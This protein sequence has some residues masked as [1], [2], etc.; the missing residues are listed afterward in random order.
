MKTELLTLAIE[1]YKKH[2]KE[3][4]SNADRIE[5]AEREN[6]YQ[7]FTA[8]K[9]KEM[10]KSDFYLYLG[11]LW[12][13]KMW[14]NKEYLIE[15]ILKDNPFEKLK[16]HLINLLYGD[17]SVSER[18][19]NFLKDVKG[20]GP[21]TISE[22][23]CYIN[24][25][26]YFIFN[27]TTVKCLSYLEA[28]NLPKHNYQ[29]TGERYELICQTAKSIAADMQNAGFNNPSLLEVDYML[30]D[31][32]LPLAQKNFKAKIIAPVENTKPKRFHDEVKGKI[33]EIGNFLN[34]KSK[35][36]VKVSDGGVVDAV[37][38]HAFNK[39]VTV[40]CVFEVHCSGDLDRMM[41]NLTRALNKSAVQAIICVAAK[42]KFAKIL[43][44]SRNST[45][46][47]RLK[48]WDIEEVDILYQNL[49]TAN[50]ILDGL[51]LNTPG[52]I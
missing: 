23:L 44:E 11:K 3:N 6:F 28:D 14:F 48:L 33:V 46:E 45:L 38:E 51:D 41:F 37:W 21:S 30:W 47:G 2:Q 35:A 25:H 19:D 43:R 50:E 49:K 31:E 52:F 40:N 26:E 32:I 7:Q 4:N 18:W 5:R 12:S 16:E 15:G 34:F 17:Y 27:K 13:M 22:L 8:A 9:I 36:E 20:I 29:Y 10:T 1:D 39:M 24:P 42:E